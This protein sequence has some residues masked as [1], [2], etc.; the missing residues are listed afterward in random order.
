MPCSVYVH[1]SS[2][3]PLIMSTS[4]YCV[5]MQSTTWN[6]NLFQMCST[7]RGNL[8]TSVGNGLLSLWRPTHGK[9]IYH[10]KGQTNTTNSLEVV[11]DQLI[12]AA[13]NGNIVIHTSFE[14]SVS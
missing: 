9:L 11:G 12:S 3:S 2:C 5:P 10:L 6:E 4:D 8:V 7:S 14:S 13:S 1:I